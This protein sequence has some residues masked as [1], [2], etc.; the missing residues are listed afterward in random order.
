MPRRS[1]EERIQITKDKLQKE[2]AR[3]ADLQKQSSKAARAAD[4]REKI[5][6]GG[7]VKIAEE[8]S[9]QKLAPDTVLGI[10]LY[11]FLSAA[12]PDKAEMIVSFTERGK[13]VLADRAAVQTT[14]TKK[15]TQTNQSKRGA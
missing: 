7:L 15:A 4:T 5:Q 6:L 2:A 1:L 11:G 8:V 13:K 14:K 3:L 12:K 9:G 10:L